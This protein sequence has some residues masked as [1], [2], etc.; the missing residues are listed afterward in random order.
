MNF[1]S[2]ITGS[3]HGLEDW[4]VSSKKDT[5]LPFLQKVIE[6]VLLTRGHTTKKL[7]YPAFY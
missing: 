2:W 5:S 1:Q 6:Q 4:H 7:F 3:N